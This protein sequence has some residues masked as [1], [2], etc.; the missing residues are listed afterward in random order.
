MKKEPVIRDICGT[1]SGY[2]KHKNSGEDKCSLCVEAYNIWRR[3]AYDPEKNRRHKETYLAKPE[4][5]AARN[6]YF[7]E[8]YESNRN[9]PEAV[10]AREAREEQQRINAEKREANRFVKQK[11]YNEK[12][13]FLSAVTRDRKADV[14]L[15][16]LFA[17]EERRENVAL[18]FFRHRERASARAREKYQEKNAGSIAARAAV[19]DL[20]KLIRE[21]KQ[22]IRAELR[23]EYL[24][25]PIEHGTSLYEYDRCRSRPEGSCELCKAAAAKW[26]REDRVKNP[27]KHR[28]HEKAWEAANP[29]KVRDQRRL[30]KNR[31]ERRAAENGQTPYTRQEI[32]ERDDYTCYLCGEKVDMTATHQMGQPGWELFPHLDHVVPLSKGGPDTPDNVRTTHARCNLNKSDKLVDNEISPSL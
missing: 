27:E 5:A 10:A 3:S 28:E 14:A 20:N 11:A 7:A 17:K 16:R 22:I 1:T 30:A 6:K 21:Q 19:A 8:L 23:Q 31:R 18:N 13:A 4:K 2:R 32:L 12:N 29:E 24:D 15:A 9:S 25:R 26:H